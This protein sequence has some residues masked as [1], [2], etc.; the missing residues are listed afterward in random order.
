MADV[1]IHKAIKLENCDH[2]Y[3]I[4]MTFADAAISL[5]SNIVKS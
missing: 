4:V 2:I 5:N 1:I 3:I